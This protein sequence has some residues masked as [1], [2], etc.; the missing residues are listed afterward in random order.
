MFGLRS[1]GGRSIILSSAA[2]S[3]Y[4]H[5][6]ATEMHSKAIASIS[7]RRLFPGRR[8]EVNYLAAMQQVLAWQQ[9]VYSKIAATNRALR[10]CVINLS[11]L[12]L[13]YGAGALYL[14][15]TV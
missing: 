7:S 6:Q 14:S 9:G 13:T 1:S 15:G 12:G 11:L 10:Y 4:E 8:T 2:G 3:D 5:H